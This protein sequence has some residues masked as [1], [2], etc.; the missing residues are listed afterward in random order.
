MSALEALKEYHKRL[1]K[2]CFGHLHA[3]EVFGPPDVS[4]IYSLINAFIGVLIIAEIDRILVLD[5][6]DLVMI[7]GS[8]GAVTTLIYAAPCSPLSQPW[9]CIV[10]NAISAFIGVSTY[11]V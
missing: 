6:V 2:A 1:K 7:V 8:F 10:G 9:N 11:K 4:V 5:H 3:P